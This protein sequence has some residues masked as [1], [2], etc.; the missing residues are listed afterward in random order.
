MPTYTNLSNSQTENKNSIDGTIFKELQSYIN[1]KGFFGTEINT[2]A[3]DRVLTGYENSEKNNIDKLSINNLTNAEGSLNSNFNTSI[4][5]RYREF[6]NMEGTAEVSAALDLLADEVIQIGDNGHI[7]KI[8]TKHKDVKDE[9]EKLFFQILKIDDTSWDK[10][11]SMCMYGNRF[12]EIVLNKKDPGVLYLNYID[13]AS[14]QRIEEKNRI[15]KFTKVKYQ[16]EDHGTTIY[17]DDKFSDGGTITPFRIVHFRIED[18]RFTPYGKSILESSR[19]TIRHLNMMEDAMLVYRYSRA[20]EK[21]VWNIDCGE[22]GPVDGMKYTELV[23]QSMRKKSNF[24]SST[25]KLNYE[26][27]PI[28]ISEDYFIPTF[29]GKTNNTVQQLAGASNLGEIDD[30]LYFKK[31]FFFALKIPLQFFSEDASLSK[32]NLALIDVRFARLIERIGRFYTRGLEKVAIVHLILKKFSAEKI[33]EFVIKLTPASNIKKQADLEF[34]TARFNA[35][36]SAKG[37]NLFPDIWILTV[38]F[39]LPIEEAENLLE[40]MKMQQ[41]GGDKAPGG[42]GGGAPGG[43]GMGDLFGGGAESGPPPSEEGGAGDVPPGAETDMGALDA[44]TSGG[45]A[46]APEVPGGDAGGDMAIESVALNKID[47]MLVENHI[48]DSQHK[49]LEYRVKR[50]AELMETFEKF[51]NEKNIFENKDNMEKM[52]REENRYSLLNLM[53][54]IDGIVDYMEDTGILTENN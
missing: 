26:V 33:K 49:V 9:L 11:R 42:A 8:E 14:I 37:T 41:G 38:I 13:P 2:G 15:I 4:I 50:Y 27:N 36:S 52:I 35:I 5:E 31:K 10:V 46:E 1:Q 3:D 29:A 28:S 43:G 6:E 54:E 23:R 34:M 20:S 48:D 45:A 24:N 25:G 53:N 32:S 30:V 12:E 21:R 47:T 22:L 40:L 39:G 19:R 44:L 16:S 18:A 7:A 51:K 17:D